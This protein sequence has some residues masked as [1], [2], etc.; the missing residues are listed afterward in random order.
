V[1][2]E[3]KGHYKLDNIPFYAQ[4]LA[5]GDLLEAEYDE[6]EQALVLADIL[7][8]SGHSTI[9][10]VILDTSVETNTIRDI[11][12][13]LGCATEKQMERYFAIDVPVNIDYKPI[14]QQLAELE[15]KEIIS[16]AVACLSDQHAS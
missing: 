14:K 11:F 6:D 5:V 2:D 13:N 7:E 4:S 16:F 15:A 1:V 3:G 9:Q 8:F 10:V 12:H